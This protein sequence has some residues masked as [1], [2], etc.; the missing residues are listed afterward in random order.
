MKPES[1]R[2]VIWR[3]VRTILL[4]DLAVFIIRAAVCWDGG[5]RTLNNFGTGLMLVGL[6]A[7]VVGIMSLAGATQIARDPTY[8]Y[9]QSVYP[10]TLHQRT[11][12]NWLELGES[13]GFV[14]LLGIAGIVPMGLGAVTSTGSPRT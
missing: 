11:V 8:R 13:Y 9:V 12:Q 14:T 6:A 2:S 3:F 4:I 10:N 1:V 5:W 7:W